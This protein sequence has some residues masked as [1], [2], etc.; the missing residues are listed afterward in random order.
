M[1]PMLDS[2]V[3]HYVSSMRVRRELIPLPEILAYRCIT[4]SVDGPQPGDTVVADQVAYD[5][6]LIGLGVYPKRNIVTSL[7]A[8][9]WRGLHLD[10][11]GGTVHFKEPQETLLYRLDSPHRPHRP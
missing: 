2:P 10:K 9:G 7:Y 8:R 1:K 3:S 11:L 5:D 6:F 4:T